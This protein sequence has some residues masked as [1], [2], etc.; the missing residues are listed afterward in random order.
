MQEENVV[1]GTTNPADETQAVPPV[2]IQPE[3]AKPEEA[4][5]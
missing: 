2:E 4:A 3:E 1:N 5:A